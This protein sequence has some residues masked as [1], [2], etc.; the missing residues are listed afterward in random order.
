MSKGNLFYGEMYAKTLKRFIDIISSLSL[1][2]VFSPICF[3]VA[4]LIKLDSKGPVFADTPKR[5]GKRNTLF[6][7]F[8]FRSMIE[9]AHTMLREDPKFK[10]LFEE[11]KRSSYKLK[12]DP[13]ITR[14]G[15]FIRKHSLDE[16]PQLFNVFRGE[17]SLVGPRAYYPD[18]IV[19]Q[20]KK[21]PVA[22][23]YLQTVIEVKPGITGFWQVYGRSEVNFDKRIKMDAEYV[24]N[25]SLWYDIKII[26]RTPWAMISGKGAV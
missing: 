23:Q 14:I 3:V 20:L 24:K 5:V 4:V 11:Y 13:R 7:M 22:K 6:K 19:E 18:E 2:I 16:L 10:Q 17:M 25:I 9:N 8:K 15:S 12:N 1:L 21:Y 26:L